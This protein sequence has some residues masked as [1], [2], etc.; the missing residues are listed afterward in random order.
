MYL[1]PTTKTMLRKMKTLKSRISS[2][3]GHAPDRGLI[4]QRLKMNRWAQGP[5]AAR[6]SITNANT[7]KKKSYQMIEGLPK[8]Y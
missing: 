6:N 8:K 2:E 4:A 3:G 1:K 7:H 5:A